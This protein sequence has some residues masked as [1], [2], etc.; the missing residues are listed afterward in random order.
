MKKASHPAAHRSRKPSPAFQNPFVWYELMTPDVEGAKAFYQKV[1]G[2]SY[3]AQPP[4]YTVCNVNDIGMGGIMETPDHLRGMPPFWTGYVF[5]PNVDR[6][7][8]AVKRRGGVVH[9]E[10]WDIP[11]MLRMAVVADPTGAVF[12][13]MQPLADSPMPP[14]APG[15]PGTVG[16]RELHTADPAAAWKF[17]SK[18]FGWSKGKTH[19]M[20]P[21]VGAYQLAQIGGTD[22]AGIMRKMPQ[23]PRSY[24][25]YYF[26]VDGI[27]AAAG[28]I[29]AAGG[30][31]MFGPME[32]P[33]NQ[34]VVT[35]QDPQGGFF[36][37]LSTTK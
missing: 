3:S 34:W 15:T 2:W 1:G 36:S 13:V 31:I 19:D 7:C 32:V 10:P 9:R 26:F 20:G 5:T 14:I 27:D 6:A 30:K 23:M 18:M 33:G 35:G 29:T 21:E 22:I 11:G 37:L 4:A 28:R 8:Q 24:W 12:Q 25:A 16:W 17:Y